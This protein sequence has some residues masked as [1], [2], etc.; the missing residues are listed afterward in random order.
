MARTLAT[1]GVASG[2]TAGALWGFVEFPR[3][4]EVT[5]RREHREAGGPGVHSS[6]ML[7]DVDV[8]RCDGIPVTSPTRTLIDLAALLPS[9]RFERVLDAALVTGSVRADRLETRA[10][11]LRHPR[12]PGCA[13][14]LRLLADRHPELAAVRSVLEAQALRSCARAGLPPPRV[15]Y[16]VV[17]GGRIRYLDLAWPEQL[18]ALE[19]DG[20]VPHSTRAV[21]DDD[22]VRQNDLVVDG[23]T[24]LR[25]TA[26]ALRAAPSAAFAPVI[27]VL[28]A[29]WAA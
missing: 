24:V 12:R 29:R 16:Q 17:T 14:V 5:V 18:V 22:R 25:L 23:W 26:T 19:L 11:A 15:S 21:F 8:T 1:G 3:H 4:I 13:T 7:E 6:R 27:A 20:F 10:R 2:A 28:Q 9:A